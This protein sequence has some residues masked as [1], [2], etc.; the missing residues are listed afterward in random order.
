M[1]LYLKKDFLQYTGRW[2]ILTSLDIL[3]AYQEVLGVIIIELYE[4]LTSLEGIVALSLIRAYLF[5][6]Q[7]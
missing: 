7:S 1:D 2:D 4:G 5:S 3:S 6:L